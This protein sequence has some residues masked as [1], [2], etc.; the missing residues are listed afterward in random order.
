MDTLLTHI[1][2]KALTF[3]E[4]DSALGKG[5]TVDPRSTSDDQFSLREAKG[6]I[7]L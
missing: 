2:I 1:D 7:Y 6:M 5:S 3:P 4:P